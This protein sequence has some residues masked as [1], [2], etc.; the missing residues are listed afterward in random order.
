M[1]RGDG[2]GW[3]EGVMNYGRPKHWIPIHKI[4][5]RIGVNTAKAVIKAHVLTGND[6]LSKVGTKYASLHYNPGVALS[7]FRETTV[8]AEHD[9]NAAEEFLVKCYSG[10]K[11]V[12][13]A[14]KF[15]ELRIMVKKGKAIG[16]DQLP[17]TSSVIRGH[18]QRA[19]FDIRNDITLLEDPPQLDPLDFGWKDVDGVL[20][21]EKNLKP[22]PDTLRK[23][24]GCAGKC[25][26]H[27][28]ICKK[29]NQICVIYCHKKIFN[30][31]LCQ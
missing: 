16:L 28:C 6:H 9:I 21:P 30:F 14:K 1:R 4:K 18:I 27:S 8:L 22:I 2:K 7:T 10:V 3:R 25:D 26:K 12:C 29:L 31:S 20:L 23:L 5:K 17:P 24:C 11:S 15:D 13:T 19:Y